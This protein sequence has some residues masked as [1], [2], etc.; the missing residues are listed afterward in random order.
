MT[1]LRCEVLVHAGGE[2]VYSLP[3]TLLSVSRSVLRLLLKKPPA[4][5]SVVTIRI[6]PGKFFL[7]EA[8]AVHIEEEAAGTAVAFRLLVELTEDEL[9]ELLILLARSTSA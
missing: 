5:G 9:R 2:T 3:A 1:K 4:L 7:R 8:E 6:R